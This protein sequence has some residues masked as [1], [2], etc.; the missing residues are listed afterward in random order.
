VRLARAL[1]GNREARR[2]PGH[3]AE[4]ESVFFSALLS[5]GELKRQGSR[6]RLVTLGNKR[7]QENPAWPA[8][9]RE[10]A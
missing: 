3:L 5:G 7:M 9:R 10:S 1:Y 4:A 6:A 8:R 2:R